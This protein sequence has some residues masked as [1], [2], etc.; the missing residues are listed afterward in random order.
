MD[1]VESGLHADLPPALLH[2]RDTVRPGSLSGSTG[3]SSFSSRMDVAFVLTPRQRRWRRRAT[4]RRFRYAA[5]TALARTTGIAATRKRSS[6]SVVAVMRMFPGVML[7]KRRGTSSPR[8]LMET[9]VRGMA[10][11][12]SARPL[13]GTLRR[14]GRRLR[15]QRIG[16]AVLLNP[17]AQPQAIGLM[18]SLV[19]KADAQVR[20][21]DPVQ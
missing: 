12:L 6:A 7:A 21:L 19:V 9:V 4:D 14:S 8:L 11:P 18:A 2:A 20:L 13:P 10:S 15:R 17:V 16:P 3:S 1:R 5:G